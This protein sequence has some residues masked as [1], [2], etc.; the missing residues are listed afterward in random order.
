MGPGLGNKTWH[1]RAG[2]S[3][4]FLKMPVTESGLLLLFPIAPYFRFED[5]GAELALLPCSCAMPCVWH[6]KPVR[7]S[8]RSNGADLT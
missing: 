1:F 6:S 5:L 8:K 7:G 3:V 4:C 2:R